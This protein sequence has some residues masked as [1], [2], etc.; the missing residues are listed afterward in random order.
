MENYQLSHWEWDSFFKD[1][2]YLIVGGGIVGLSAAIRIKQ[3]A[4]ASKVLVVDRGSLPIGASTRNAG[5]ACFGSLSELIDDL[6][7]STLDEILALVEKRYQGL[8]LLRQRYGDKQ[9]GYEAFGGFEV[10][11]PSDEKSYEQCVAQMAVFN[12]ALEAIIG[13]KEVYKLAD[14]K[15]KESGLAAVEHIIHNQ[16]E[17]QLHTGQLMQ[18]LIQKMH[19][20]GIQWLGGT[21][22]L[23]LEESNGEVILQTQQGWQIKCKQL[24]VATNGFAQQLLPQLDVQPARNHI[25]IT[26]PIKNLSLKGSFHYDKGYVYFRNVGNRILLGGGRNLALEAEQTSILGSHDEIRAYLRNILEQ[27][28]APQHSVQIDRWWSGIMGVGAQKR[29]ILERY[30]QNIVLAVRL[31]G[32]GVALGTGVGEAAADLVLGLD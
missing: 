16:A 28:I 21:E 26:A 11:R 7:H 12:T 27:T 5:F 15:I 4:P 19:N 23:E 30:G 22:V 9:I 32:M 2:D 18:T 3:L 6:A 17:G 1:T 25:L 8:A 24:V 20:L 31:G 13:Q 14:A 29:P 10:F